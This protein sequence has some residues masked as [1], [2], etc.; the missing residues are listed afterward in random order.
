[1][2]APDEIKKIPLSRL[3]K[4]ESYCTF[5]SRN[6]NGKEIAMSTGITE[7]LFNAQ[8]MMDT[9]QETLIAFGYDAL[10][11]LSAHIMLKEYQT[12]LLVMGGE[13]VH[14]C[15]AF[16][17]FLQ[18]PLFGKLDL[19]MPRFENVPPEPDTDCVRRIVACLDTEKPDAVIAVG[20]GSVMDAAKA[21]YLS[22][23]TGMDIDRLFGR[24]AA[25]SAFPGLREFTIPM[26]PAESCAAPHKRNNM[27]DINCGS[28][29]I[30][31]GSGISRI[32]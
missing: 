22:W 29:K 30:P 6:L 18:S 15:G 10:D 7:T 28:R 9:C 5:I 24:E 2:P 26:I 21:A 32:I 17:A 12:I 1:M 16:H 27:P 31:K 14:R 13:S 3:K 25:T 19:N 8:T 20:G 23:Q 4:T 11:Q